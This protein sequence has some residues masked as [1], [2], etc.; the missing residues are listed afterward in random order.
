MK[1]GF[2]IA[3]LKQNE[4]ALFRKLWTSLPKKP[5]LHTLPGKG[6]L[7]LLGETKGDLFIDYLSCRITITVEEYYKVQQSDQQ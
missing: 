3:L 2:I 6:C 7:C 1:C 5:K 4:I